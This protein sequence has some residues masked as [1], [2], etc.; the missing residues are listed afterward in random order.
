MVQK[1]NASRSIDAQ[2]HRRSSPVRMPPSLRA[3]TAS[4][5]SSRSAVG[6]DMKA[7]SSASARITRGRLSSFM[8]GSFTRAAG[9]ASSVPVSIIQLKNRTSSRRMWSTLPFE[10]PFAA[11]ASSTPLTFARSMAAGS[12]GPSSGVTW[13]RNRIR[14]SS[15]MTTPCFSRWS[16]KTFAS[17]STFSTP[18]ATARASSNTSS[19]RSICRTIFACMRSAR[20]RSCVSS[21]IGLRNVVPSSRS[22]VTFRT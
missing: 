1:A 20:P 8:G 16:T 7:A 22:I 9:F 12:M 2:S 5:F 3:T 4:S 11:A 10:S 18:R 19:P 21:G 13:S 14:S 17:F 6:D 15:A